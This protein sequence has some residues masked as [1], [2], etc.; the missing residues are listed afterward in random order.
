MLPVEDKRRHVPCGV[1]RAVT[2]AGYSAG[3]RKRPAGLVQGRHPGQ[4][5]I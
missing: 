4:H 2:E 1:K 3:P 5:G